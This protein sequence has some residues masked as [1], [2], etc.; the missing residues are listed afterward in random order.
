[1]VQWIFLNNTIIR[2]LAAYDGRS[3]LADE[4]DEPAF[5]KRTHQ[6]KAFFNFD[7]LPDFAYLLNALKTSSSKDLGF[8]CRQTLFEV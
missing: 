2:F 4:H 7:F 3:D 6:I 5:G 8:M 1:M